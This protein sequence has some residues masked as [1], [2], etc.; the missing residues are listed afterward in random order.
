MEYIFDQCS[1]DVV[2]MANNYMYDYGP[3]E[4]MDTR[5]LILGKSIQ[6]TGASNNWPKHASLTL[7]NVK[8]PRLGI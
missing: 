1:F 2:T 8:A 7:L 4:L 6:T 3:D 5:D